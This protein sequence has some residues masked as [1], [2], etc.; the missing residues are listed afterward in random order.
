MPPWVAFDI[1][2]AVFL[3]GQLLGLNSSNP[4]PIWVRDLIN[5][6]MKGEPNGL[7]SYILTSA[8]GKYL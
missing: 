7:A 4:C 8:K 2:P 6:I 1:P 5:A 3:C